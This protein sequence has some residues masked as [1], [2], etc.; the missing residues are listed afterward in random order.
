[1]EKLSP[2]ELEKLRV[3][4]KRMITVFVVTMVGLLVVIA[5]DLVIGLSRT[6]AWFAFVGLLGLAGLG[7]VIQFSQRCPRCEYRLGFQSRLLV[8]ENCKKCGVGL[9]DRP[10]GWTAGNLTQPPPPKPARGNAKREE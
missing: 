2:S 8:P 4:Q 10:I 9:K 1:M 5:S 3:W 7:A 6:V